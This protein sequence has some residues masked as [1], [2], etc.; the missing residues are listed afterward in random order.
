VGGQAVQAVGKTVADTG[1]T[2]DA[3]VGKS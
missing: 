3:A 2:A 1:I